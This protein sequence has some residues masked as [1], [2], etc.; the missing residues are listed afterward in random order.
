MHTQY[1][2][3]KP[4]PYPIRELNRNFRPRTPVA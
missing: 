2:L 1:R 3:I 4:T